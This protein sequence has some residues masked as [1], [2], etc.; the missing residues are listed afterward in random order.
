MKSEKGLK[1]KKEKPH[2]PIDINPYTIGRIWL[3]VMFTTRL[4]TVDLGT[5]RK[6]RLCLLLNCETQFIRIIK[7]VSINSNY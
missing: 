3:K 2:E 1:S 6:T 7:K 4:S 5:I